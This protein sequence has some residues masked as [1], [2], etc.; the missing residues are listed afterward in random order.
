[1]AAHNSVYEAV[2]GEVVNRRFVLLRTFCYTE[3]KVLL[4]RYCIYTHNAP[5]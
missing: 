1:M 2:A 3:R 4:V 5:L